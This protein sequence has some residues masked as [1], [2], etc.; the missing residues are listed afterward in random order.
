MVKV[1]APALDVWGQRATDVMATNAEVVSAVPAALD[2]LAVAG[3]FSASAA[4]YKTSSALADVAAA[5]WAAPGAWA[6][7]WVAVWDAWDA[8]VGAWAI[9]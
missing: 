1:K 2:A 9:P 7:A 3:D 5:A 4:S 8:W 6:A